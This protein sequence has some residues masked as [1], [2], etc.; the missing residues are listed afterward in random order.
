M[1][2]RMTFGKSKMSQWK[3]RQWKL[4]LGQVK[5]KDMMQMKIESVILKAKTSD[6]C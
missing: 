6:H 1:N 3:Q 2:P 5:K 4:M